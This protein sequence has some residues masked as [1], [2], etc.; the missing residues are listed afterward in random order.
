MQSARECL[1]LVKDWCWGGL[2]GPKLLEYIKSK[3]EAQRMKGSH[4]PKR[5]SQVSDGMVKII[6]KVRNH[7]VLIEMRAEPLRRL[8]Q[9]AGGCYPRHVAMREALELLDGKHDIRP[10]RSGSSWADSA[11][12]KWSVMAKHAGGV[13]KTGARAPG[14]RWDLSL[15]HI[16]EPTRP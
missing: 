7:K 5:R 3:I 9:V 14:I 6:G 16:S 13:D 2:S 11:A 10:A 8:L 1:S 12:G 4:W 15:I